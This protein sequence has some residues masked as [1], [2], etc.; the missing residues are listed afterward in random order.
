MLESLQND[1][2]L[3]A[4]ILL[5]DLLMAFD[6]LIAKLHSYGFSKISLNLFNNYLCE[7]IQ[8]NKINDKFSTW[9]KVIYGVPRRSILGPLFFN[10]Y[11]RPILIVSEH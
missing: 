10:I 6:L 11:I 4:G 7:R 2:G 8:R 9:R 1:K 3:H 5:T